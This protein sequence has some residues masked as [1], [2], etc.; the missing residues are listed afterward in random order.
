MSLEE[1]HHNMYYQIDYTVRLFYLCSIVLIYVRRL[2][3][4]HYVFFPV[5]VLIIHPKSRCAY[6]FVELKS[7]NEKSVCGLLTKSLRA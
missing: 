6:V 5:F 4:L 3:L 2:T 7:G 1:L